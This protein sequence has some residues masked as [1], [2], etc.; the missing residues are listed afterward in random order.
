MKFRPLTWRGAHSYVVADRIEDIT[1]TELIRQN[2]KCD[3][4]II[5]YGYVRGAPMNKEFM[6]HI[7]GFGDARINELSK[8]S[9]PCPLPGTEKKRNL[10]EKER[11][12]YAPMSGVGG[13]VYDKDAVYIELQGS[14]S[15][16]EKI[17]NTE[18][19]ELV[20]KLKE[21]KQTINEQLDEQ[22]FRLF[23]DGDIIKSKNFKEDL[24][25]ADEESNDEDDDDD[26]DTSDDDSGL[27][28]DNS[29]WK[30][31]SGNDSDSDEDEQSSDEEYQEEDKFKCVEQ[32]AE[33]NDTDDE[34]QKTNDVNENNMKWKEGLEGRAREAY[35]ERQSDS[36]N[37]MKLVYGVYNE[38]NREK[39]Q[40]DGDESDSEIIGGLFKVSSKK[41]AELQ[42]NKDIMD[43]EESCFFEGFTGKSRDWLDEENKGLIKNCFV[44]GKWKPSEDAEELLKLDDLS[45]AESELYGDFVD[46]ETGEKHDSNKNI[47]QNSDQLTD[48]TNDKEI[49]R[50][51]N[52][53][54]VEEEN[55]TKTELMAKK[56]KLK[57]KFD[58]EY[59]NTGGPDEGRITGDH[60]YY[61]SLK[62]EAQRQ[63]D[64]N[65]SEF[66]HL[67]DDLR[68]QI[69]GY[70][71]GLYIRMGF[72]NI[73]SEFIENLD[74]TYPIL[75]GGLN[76]AEENIG[77]V[78][79]KV[80][81]HRWYKKTLK[82]ADPLII[83]L[84]WRRFQTCPIYAKVEDNFRQRYLKYTPNHITCSMTFWG[85]I[86]PQNTGFLAIQSVNQDHE[87]IKR[88][89]F[90]IAATGCV[91]ELDKSSQI[92]KKLK[93][94][95]VPLKIYQKTAFIKGM[96]NTNLEVA[97]FEGAKIKTVS[98]IR[99]QIKKAHNDPPGSFRATFEDRILLSDIVFCRTWFRVDVPQFYTP[100]TSLLLPLDKKTQWQGMKTLGQLKREKQIRNLPNPDSLY[101][102][103]ERK[104]KIFR[105]LNIPK[106]LQKALPY[107]YKPKHGPLNP[108]SDI[109]RIA[110]IRSPHEQKIAN[111]MKMIE[112]NYQDKKEKEKK[113]TEERLAK[114]KI[115]KQGDELRKLK[116][117]KEVRK[118]IS[119][120]L[121]KMKRKQ[122]S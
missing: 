60:Q 15:H 122:N 7:A 62:A 41:Q 108:T 117:E 43:C 11:L 28:E 93:L 109:K 71:S 22:E 79:C 52:M 63:S 10:L 40:T 75:I 39:Q 115:Q 2:P 47:K 72:K 116:R 99:G 70:R 42:K 67:D 56:M 50:K 26:E 91:T 98:G 107:K 100:V 58:A 80:K 76:I 30:V 8:L 82:T 68:V 118:K 3:R 110:V 88:L 119:R 38:N 121:S 94:V 74:P 77:Y 17:I 54:R 83:S 64:L 44:T 112:T 87:E 33:S 53:T 90:R 104:E 1:N 32:N 37:L 114:F 84:G 86:T 57:A 59:D 27:D 34:Y 106:S 4:D 25:G 65:K 49:S 45:D 78:S 23:S 21:K 55:L 29:G 92:M 101:T 69:E 6:V 31:E 73:S 36:K 35:L 96:F 61:D 46:L 13:I 103:I 113:Q 19:E 9:D 120:A 89:G 24:I 66:S 48:T 12:L 81:K 85:P 14:H 102:E 105:P 16:K 18:Q 5:L 20:N 51:R 95:G 111:M 97:K